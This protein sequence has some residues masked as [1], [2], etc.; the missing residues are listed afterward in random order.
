MG[1]QMK[2]IDF[3]EKPA[4]KGRTPAAQAAEERRPSAA[5]KAADPKP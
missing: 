5:A 3:E 2:K 4:D 1:K